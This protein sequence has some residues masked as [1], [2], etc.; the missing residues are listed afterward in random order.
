MCRVGKYFYKS[1]ELKKLKSSNSWDLYGFLIS[2]SL[3]CIELKN[4]FHNFTKLTNSFCQCFYS[5]YRIGKWFFS[6]LTPG[7]STIVSP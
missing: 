1:N 3:V 4:N 2:G 7:F 5:V 6:N